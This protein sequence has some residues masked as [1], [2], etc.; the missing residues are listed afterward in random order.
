MTLL[1]RLAGPMQSW[2][3]AS[4]FRERDTEREP[5]KSGV[6]GLVAAALG[7]PRTAPIADLAA[8][9]MGV[10]VDKEGTLQ[11]DYHTVGG[12][13]W[14]D[15]RYAR[16]DAER[17]GVAE[18]DGSVTK[19]AIITNRYYLADADF[20]VG[21]A[22]H[23]PAQEALL[24][25]IDAALRHPVWPLSLGRKAF[26]PGVPVRLPDTPPVGPGL[27]AG[28]LLDVLRH[29]PWPPEAAGAPLR[30]IRDDPTGE[31]TITRQDVPLDFDPM[32]RRYQAR[33]III[34]EVYP[35]ADAADED[36]GS[37][38]LAWRE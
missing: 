21:L 14:P 22:A 23:T 11:R 30:V 12:S 29:Y 8:L 7:R 27:R 26:V 2:G 13:R 36:D 9:E 33:S 3:T 35:P 15:H 38:H 24:H 1:V 25:D 37:V 34:E 10:R 20:L 28:E 19:N 17:Y 4:K 6:V 16:D 32:R 31:S 18:F 5:S